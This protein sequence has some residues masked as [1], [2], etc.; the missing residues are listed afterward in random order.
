MLQLYDIAVVIKELVLFDLRSLHLINQII[1]DLDHLVVVVD[2][3]F[4][5]VV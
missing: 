4:N 1:P 3:T 2:V 5:E